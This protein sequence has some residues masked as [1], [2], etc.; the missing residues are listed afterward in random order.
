MNWQRY[1]EFQGNWQREVVLAFDPVDKSDPFL[2]FR[3]GQYRKD[4]KIVRLLPLRDQFNFHGG[5]TAR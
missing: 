1:R 2:E 4:G 5:A 3:A